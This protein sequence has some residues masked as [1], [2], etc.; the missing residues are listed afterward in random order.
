MYNFLLSLLFYLLCF[1]SCITVVDFCFN[2]NMVDISGF[3]TFK[4]DKYNVLD[5]KEI[6]KTNRIFN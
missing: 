1:N 3:N 4:G 5:T 6:R 2:N